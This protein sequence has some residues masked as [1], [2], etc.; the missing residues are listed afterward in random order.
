[1]DYFTPALRK[2]FSAPFTFKKLKFLKSP[3]DSKK[4]NDYS[5]PCVIIAGNG[6]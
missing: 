1:M 4:M 2:E 5:G 6:M 3:D